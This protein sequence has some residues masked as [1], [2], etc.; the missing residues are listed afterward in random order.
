MS[1]TLQTLLQDV[2]GQLGLTTNTT[3]AELSSAT[4][5]APT[6]TNDQVMT[7]FLNSGGNELARDVY[8][9]GATSL[10][11]LGTNSSILPLLGIQDGSGRVFHIIRNL[12]IGAIKIQNCGYEQL[13]TGIVGFLDSAP[14]SSCTYY[15]T[16]GADLGFQ[17]VL[18]AGTVLTIMGYA[19][20]V[21]LDSAN[22]TT[23]TVDR[24]LDFDAVTAMTYYAC[25]KVCEMQADNPD[26]YAKREEYQGDYM[27]S[28][29]TLA[30]RLR[31]SDVQTMLAYFPAAIGLSL[32]A[33]SK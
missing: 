29:I 32:D 7:G 15:Y 16:Q 9:I 24:V 18:L 5:G 6:L 10:I 17:Q 25:W 33:K 14:A 19:L 31:A 21:P 12:K 22:P 13:Q 1:I 27:R 23:S 2:K 28:K 3:V 11:V 20:P 4:P 26:L 8:P 30:K